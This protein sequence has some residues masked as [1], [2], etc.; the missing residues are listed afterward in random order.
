M[1]K[2]LVRLAA[3]FLAAP[4]PGLGLEDADIPTDAPADA[5]MAGPEEI[6]AMQEWAAG[7]FQDSRPAG[8]ETQVRVEVRRQDHSVLRIGQSCIE[9]PLKIGRREFARGL[10]THA[11]SEIVLHLPPGARV[12]KAFAGID[13]NLD[14]QGRHGTA[15]FSVEAGGKELFRTPTLR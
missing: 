9:T 15:Q 3:L 13:N 14:T 8:D 2:S 7:A 4:L 10:G 6:H 12:F 1:I 11:N 5:L